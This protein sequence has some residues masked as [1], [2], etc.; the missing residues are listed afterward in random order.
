LTFRAL[1]FYRITLGMPFAPIPMS[2][3][4]QELSIGHCVTTILIAIAAMT[5]A[6]TSYGRMAAA[7]SAA[8]STYT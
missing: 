2:S 8:A 1:I 7:H 4:T 6:A 3:I 5:F